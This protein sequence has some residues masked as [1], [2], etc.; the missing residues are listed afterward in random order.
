MGG[1]TMKSVAAW[2][3]ILAIY[4]VGAV[5][6]TQDSG[7][8]DVKRPDGTV[9]R[10]IAPPEPA[11]RPYYN[12]ESPARLEQERAR[13]AREEENARRLEAQRAG[14]EEELER[15]KRERDAAADTPAKR[16]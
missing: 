2:A 5:A 13:Q 7:A 11:A 8:R 14:R 16:Q 3:T 1:T 15:A 4:S 12:P 6:Q 10:P 9:I